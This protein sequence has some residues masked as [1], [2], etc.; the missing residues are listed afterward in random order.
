MT[1]AEAREMAQP[2]P[3]KRAS[4]TVPSAT[5]TWSTRWSPQSGLS[6]SAEAVAPSSGPKFRGRLPWSRMTSW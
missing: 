6:P 2:V 3:V 1:E 5:F 4:C